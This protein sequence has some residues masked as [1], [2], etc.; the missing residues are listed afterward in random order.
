MFAFWGSFIRHIQTS[1]LSNIENDFYG[2]FA[3]L[4]FHQ[5]ASFPLLTTKV[6]LKIVLQDDL[7]VIFLFI[8]SHNGRIIHYYES[9]SS[10]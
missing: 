2:F 4:W 7:L 1:S 10:L 9:G 3:P 6:L 8:R 5:L